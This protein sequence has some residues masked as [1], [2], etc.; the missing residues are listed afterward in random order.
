M[1]ERQADHPI[2]PLFLERWSPRA[3]DGSEVPDADLADD[4]R[5]GALGAL[6]VQLAALALPLRQARRRGLGA[7]PVAAHPLEPELGAHRL[8]AGL[9][10]LGQPAVHR[11]GDRRAG[12]LAPPTAS[13][14]AP[15]GSASRCRRPGWAITPTACRASSTSS[16]A[17]SSA[18]PTATGSNAA[19]VIGR[20]GDPA[21]LDEK[22]RARENPSDR[23][24]HRRLRLRAAT[25]RPE[26]LRSRAFKG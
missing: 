3:F 8:G 26:G 1:T 9:H 18:C 25:F 4:V 15:P 23:K 7:L 19:C 12:A 2:D 16:P 14:P 17:P 5:G 10:P 20:I 21:Q 22:L 11:Q 24:P 6:G 13:M